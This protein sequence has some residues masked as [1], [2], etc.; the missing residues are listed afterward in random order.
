MLMF[1][2]SAFVLFLAG[3]TLRAQT[4]GLDTATAS[5]VAVLLARF[6]AT[7]T[8]AGKLDGAGR[9]ALYARD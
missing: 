9:A 3:T 4:T 2:L 1:R 6:D 7:A 5:G 8:A